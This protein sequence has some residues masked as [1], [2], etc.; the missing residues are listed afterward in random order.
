MVVNLSLILYELLSAVKKA[1]Q[2]YVWIRD[3]NIFFRD[4]HYKRIEQRR[5]KYQRKIKKKKMEQEIA[6]KKK[7]EA[8]EK[9]DKKKKVA[10]KKADKKK[11]EEKLAKEKPA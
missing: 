3:W 1:R 9:A 2:R 6:D 11:E 5:A 4:L 10:D 8:Q 7:K